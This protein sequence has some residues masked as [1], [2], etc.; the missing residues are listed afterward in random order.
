MIRSLGSS[1]HE[2]EGSGVMLPVLKVESNYRNSAYYD[3][4]LTVR[5]TLS[6]MPTVKMKFDYEVY[7]EN[8]ELINTASVTLAFMNSTTRKACR[9]P[10]WFVDIIKPYFEK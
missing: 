7:R 2:L 6:R 8:G 1:N 5:V 9:P 10:G 3:D 4:L